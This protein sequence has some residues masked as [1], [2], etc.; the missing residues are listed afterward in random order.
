VVGGALAVAKVLDRSFPFG[1]FMLVGA[2]MGVLLGPWL[3]S[4]S[5]Y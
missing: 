2:A 1:P 4:A 5:P 3:G